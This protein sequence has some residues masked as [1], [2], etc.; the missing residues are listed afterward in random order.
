MALD[1]LKDQEH[2]P[3]P[4]LLKEANWTEADLKNFLKRWEALSEESKA[5]VA[6]KHE[7]DEALRSLGLS[8]PAAKKRQGGKASDA[9][10][11]IGDGQSRVAPPSRYRD[12]FEA[13]RSRQAK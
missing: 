4:E 12:Q 13:F 1:Y 11:G 5:D 9:V 8:A 6:K 7:L 2:N 3:D 10:R